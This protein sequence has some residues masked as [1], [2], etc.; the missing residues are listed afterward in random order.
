MTQRV[1]DCHHH[2]LPLELV[3]HLEHF[4]T[5]GLRVSRQGGLCT[6]RDDDGR[7]VLSLD[8]ASFCEVGLHL[9]AMDAAGIDLALLSVGRAAG[10]LSLAGARVV[11]DAYADLVAS[12]GGRFE[13]IAFVPPSGDD[14]VEELERAS[15]L[16][17]RGVCVTGS[18]NGVY[19][20]DASCL[21][22]LRRAAELDLPVVVHPGRGPRRLPSINVPYPLEGAPVLD[23]HLLTLRLLENTALRDE[24]Q[25]RLLIPHLGGSFY[26]GGTWRQPSQAPPM[27]SAWAPGRVLFDTG[28]SFGNGPQHVALALRTLGIEHLALGSDFPIVA[29]PK[30]L[31]DAVQHIQSLGLPVAAADQMLGGNAARFFKL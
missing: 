12:S 25:L 29:D 20:D 8:V 5:E 30:T 27:L 16:G 19:L 24:R 17:L 6:V 31:A 4:V 11:N 14:A 21:A 18:R 3:G 10:C 9:R 28:P 2:W 13:G 26:V 22:F 7:E 23:M 1:I 15:A